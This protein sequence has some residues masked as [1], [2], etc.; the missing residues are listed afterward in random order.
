[1]SAE[2]RQDAW[3]WWSARRRR[4]NVVLALAGGAACLLYLVALA[5]RCAD[6][7]GVEVTLFTTAFQ[8]V[9]YLI[10]MG[11]ANLCYNLGPA[12]EPRLGRRDVAAYRRA[13]FRAGLWFSAGLPFVIPALVFA[14][15]CQPEPP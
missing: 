1:M 2:S 15:G 3:S 7:P 5:V 6:V 4:Y 13:A 9:G 14:L 12:L 8:G 10:A 11:V